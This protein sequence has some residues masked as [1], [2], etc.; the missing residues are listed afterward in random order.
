MAGKFAKIVGTGMYVPPKVVTNKDLES[1]MDTTD[2]WIKQRSGILE[3]RHVEGKVGPADLAY[4][5]TK[6]ALEAS[7]KKPEDIDFIILTTLAG[8]H[9]FP[10]SS[11]LLQHKLGLEST[12]AMDLRCQ[13]SGFLYGLNVGKHFVSSGAYKTVLVVG[14]EAHSPVLNFSTEGRDV[15]VLF[16]DG[17]GAA[18]LEASEEPGQG[19]L[20]CHLHS[21]GAFA[22]KLWMERPGTKD[23]R[24]LTSEDVETGRTWPKMDGRF[25][26]KHAT[27]RMA[28]VIRESLKDNDL[29]VDDI[30]HFL[31]H[32]ANIR[33]ND[34]VA[35]SLKIP[36]EKAYNNIQKYGNCSSASIPMLLDECIRMGRIKRGETVMMTAFGSGF[37]WGSVLM[38]Y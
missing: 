27:T 31:F 17:S 7:G 22:D 38:R 19:I 13:C 33:I 2:E 35:K 5:A 36:A 6:K 12:P 29:S 16:G 26:F 8:D 14:A 34:Y 10:G 21:Q 15:A 24:W 30:D 1:M 4:E 18:I 32:Q 3:R 28:E 9:Q 25:V 37:T 23:E 20:S 11:A